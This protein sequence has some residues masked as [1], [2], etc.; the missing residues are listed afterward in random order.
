MGAIPEAGSTGLY[1]IQVGAYIVPRN[2]VD[3]FDKLR[4]VGLNPAYERHEGFYRVVL[5][6]LRAGEINTVAQR[7]GN[8]GFREAI[9]RQETTGN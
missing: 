4:A 2:A 6:G 5:P 8:A 1:R 9:I 7:L 3:V